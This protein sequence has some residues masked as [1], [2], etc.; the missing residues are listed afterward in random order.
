MVAAEARLHDI[1]SA[2]GWRGDGSFAS[3]QLD[4]LTSFRLNTNSYVEIEGDATSIRTRMNSYADTHISRRFSLL[5]YC[6]WQS[7]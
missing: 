2:K 4:D 7:S 5:N 1:A 3:E 6:Q